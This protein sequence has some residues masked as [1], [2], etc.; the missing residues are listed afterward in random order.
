MSWSRAEPIGKAAQKQR[1][2]MAMRQSGPTRYMQVSIGDQIMR[3]MGWEKGSRVSVMWG[4]GKDFGWLRLE[5]QPEGFLLRNQQKGDGCAGVLSTTRV[6][7][8]ACLETRGSTLCKWRVRESGLEIEPPLW[9]WGKECTV[10][11]H[12]SNKVKSALLT[13]VAAE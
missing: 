1:V 6:H 3:M 9:F 8:A 2:T 7:R 5:S 12:K 4:E 11:V 13:A 10:P